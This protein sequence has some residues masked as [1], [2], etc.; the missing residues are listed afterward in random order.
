VSWLFWACLSI[1]SWGVWGVS[2]KVAL[3]NARWARVVLVYYAISLPLIV[4]VLLVRS[5]GSSFGAA[6]VV[7]GA[8]AGAAGAVGIICLY[9]SLARAK[10]S[11]VVPLTGMFPIVSAL[12]SVVFLD[13]S[14]SA[15]QI[16]GVACAAA[17][18]LL[19]SR[20]G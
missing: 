3:A 5:D 10:A 12:L 9:V 15:A 16:A 20:G 2:S 8:F 19:I 14:L 4:V 7:A 1:A 17:A 11:I 18:V 13:E 6:G